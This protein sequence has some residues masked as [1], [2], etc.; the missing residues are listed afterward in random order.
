MTEVKY[1]QC[2][3]GPLESEGIVD[4]LLDACNKKGIRFVS[5]VDDASKS[6]LASYIALR[7]E[8]PLIII[9]PNDL[10]AQRLTEDIQMFIGG[11]AS[12]MPSREI[13]F[14]R[15][16]AS[17]RE[18]SLRR[19]DALGRFVSGDIRVL[20]VPADSLMH[21]LMP[22]SLFSNSIIDI[23]E[24]QQ[25]DPQDIVRD[26][27][28]AGYERVDVVEVRGQCALRGG[29]LDVYPVGTANAVRIE[30]FDDIV[31]SL[32]SFDVMTQRSI[33]RVQSIKIY[34]S[35]ETI[36]THEIA[37]KAI[38]R[39]NAS[40]EK[41]EGAEEGSKDITIQRSL[42][43][44]FDLIPYEEFF[45]LTEDTELEEMPSFSELEAVKRTDSSQKS[46]K[47]K[48]GTS[49]IEKNFAPYID[50]LKE[51]HLVSHLSSEA[52]MTILYDKAVFLFDYA[53]M[54]PIIILDQ[55]DRI[56][57]RCENRY[58]EFLEQYKM[59]LSRSEVLPEQA[60]LVADWS[61]VLSE[62]KKYSVTA[63]MQ[64]KRTLDWLR[65]D[66]LF[67]YDTLGA[68]SYQNNI[69]EFVNDAQK[70]I[71][72]G[73]KVF[74]LSGGTARG[75]RINKS[76]ND[77]SCKSVF[78]EQVPDTVSCSVVN[79]I[80]LPLSKG[81]LFPDAKTAF[82]SDADIFGQSRQR[83]RTKM[84]SG[85]KVA[86]FTDL[87]VGDYVVHENHGVGQFMGIVRLASEGKYRDFL[88]IRYEGTDKLYVPTDQLDRVQKY[89][90][91]DGIT[92]KL[93][94][95][96]GTEWQKQKARVKANIL[97]IA[98]EL[99][100]LY[101]ARSEIQGYAFSP[102]TAWQQQFEDSF[103]FEETP[104]Q[105][106]AIA[107]IKADMEKPKVMDRLLCGDVGYGKTEVALRAVFK[108]VMDNKQAAI[109]APTTI[110]VQQHYQTIIKRFEGFPVKVETVSRFKTAAEVKKIIQRLKDGDID[111]IV[112]THRLLGKD[113]DFKSLGLLVVDEE[114]RFGVKHKE[115]IKQLKKSIDVLTLTATPIPRTLHM[116]MV[117][118]R[119]M[120]ILQTPPEER[121]PVQTYV[122]EYSDSLVRDAIL[123]ELSRN[124]QVYIL[125]N[126][127]QFIDIMYTRLKKLV[128]EAR[129]AVGHGQMREHALED[130]MLDFYAGKYDVLLCTTIIEAGLDVPRANTLIVCDSERFG[131]A[132]L[133]QLRGRVGRS[134]K[135]AYAYLTVAP[136]RILTE[137]ADKRLSAIREFTE[138]G[139]GFRVAM[140]DL[141]I[142]GTGNLLGSEQ[143]GHMASVGYDMYVKM[144]E[145]TVSELRGDITRGDITT[146]I[147][148]HV[149]AFLPQEY[150]SSDVTR[151]ELYKKIAS[152]SDEDS[153]Y[154][155][156]E[157]I[158]DRFG[159]PPKPV[160]N[161]IDIAHLKGLCSKLG[162]DYLSENMTG[163]SMRF[164]SNANIDPVLPIKSL[165]GHEKNMK[166]KPGSSTYLEYAPPPKKDNS[167]E[168]MIKDLIPEMEAIV[169]SF[170]DRI[171]ADADSVIE[172]ALNENYFNNEV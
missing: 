128:P 145:D 107:E 77:L 5:G 31:D 8:K 140:R 67:Q 106:Q 124:G 155:L 9:T 61:E 153:R 101:A 96:S 50:A 116:S 18:V 157:E 141:E 168:K 17:S 69:R 125:Y 91:S 70:W 112:G 22:L 146:R 160:L 93:N 47:Q 11:R 73:W 37:E 133:Y 15:V 57:E 56:K 44:Q 40:L 87:K 139:S 151:V 89:I 115:S 84:R 119:D 137:S 72:D 1:P 169:K 105:L 108:C 32:R 38:G 83:T 35:S 24:G 113:V 75:I 55:P 7:S 62:I 163:I 54:D 127:V 88:H 97:D 156:I 131:L 166:F 66:A 6:Y 42:E 154:E 13:S 95:L 144:I 71:R 158:V 170:M 58:L 53:K 109:L 48:R 167:T 33:D 43:K 165:S 59:A 46:S 28:N 60:D 162:I 64:I 78:S 81:F 82:F 19:L 104:D 20:V 138:F 172:N 63:F 79:I 117:G 118:I 123:R 34:P 136:N 135:L 98:K 129:I 52:L 99:V 65:P 16:A 111:I 100:A 120:S 23:S 85:E 36:I 143:S 126:R 41:K 164:S 132:Q 142:R 80:P 68:A 74:V 26:L 122:L 102:D 148:L 110:L 30:F 29:I 171:N 2:L 27:T 86:S 51:D 130:V 49:E 3:F 92:P 94:R 10:A 12:L 114:Q 121:Y 152:I 159:D 21:R 103:E 149:D 90:G 150:I 147:E 161:L 76:L 39:I 134:N 4:P 14:T 45:Q 25:A